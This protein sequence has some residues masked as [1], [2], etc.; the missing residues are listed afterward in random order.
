MK[1]VRE[2]LH[3]VADGKFGLG[4]EFSIGA[5]F[6]AVRLRRPKPDVWVLGHLQWPRDEPDPAF[7]RN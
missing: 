2:S 7:S 3:E 6:L 5:R 1:S 4:R